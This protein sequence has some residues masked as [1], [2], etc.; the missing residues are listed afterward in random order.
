MDNNK[1][2]LKIKKTKSH[3]LVYFGSGWDF[4]PVSNSIFNKFNHFIFI[5][6]L[7]KLSHYEPGVTGYEK[8]KDR[9]AFIKT[10]KKEA[11]KHNLKSTSIRKNL[12]TFKNDKI[13]LEYY[14]NTT[15]EEALTNPTIRKKINKATCYMRMD[16]D[17]MIMG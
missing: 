5:D 6:S 14:I 1:N 7:P 17:L 9:E 3:T 12:L 16:S 13:K 15:V 2:Q 4:K 11:F 8:S 10:L